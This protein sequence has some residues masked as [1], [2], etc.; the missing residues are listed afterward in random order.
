MLS[1]STAM[2]IL[3]KKAVP[4]YLVLVKHHDIIL[5]VSY[6]ENQTFVVEYFYRAMFDE[7]QLTMKVSFKVS[8]LL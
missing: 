6:L 7:M 8:S 4:K 1:F 5:P 3:T 2:K